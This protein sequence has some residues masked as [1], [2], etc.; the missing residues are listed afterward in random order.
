MGK[1]IVTSHYQVYYMGIPPLRK[2][3]FGYI[4]RCFF[5]KLIDEEYDSH[6]SL[7]AVT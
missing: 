4:I 6:F 5:C 3:T 2:I 1:K 7:V